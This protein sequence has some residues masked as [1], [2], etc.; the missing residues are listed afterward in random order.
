MAE[1]E[2][3]PGD[4]GGYIEDV[5]EGVVISVETDVEFGEE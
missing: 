4:T 1:L 3:A 5:F 2:V